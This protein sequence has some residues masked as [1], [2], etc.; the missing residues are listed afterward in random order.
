MFM[1]KITAIICLIL[2]IIII[3]CSTKLGCVLANMNIDGTT[4]LQFCSYID[5]YSAS[6]R[7]FGIMIILFPGIYGTIHK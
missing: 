1:K 2:G 6:F 5:N 4:E 3:I 7:L